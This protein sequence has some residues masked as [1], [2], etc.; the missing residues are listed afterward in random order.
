MESANH[1]RRSLNFSGSALLLASAQRRWAATD[2]VR[3]LKP[4]LARG[5]SMKSPL[6]DMPAS[7][8]SMP[9][10]KTP[11]TRITTLRNGV[12]VATEETYG[13][14]TAMGVFIDA[15]SR[16]E[17]FETNGTTHV[18]QRMGFKVHISLAR[19]Q[20]FC[21]SSVLM[22]FTRRQATSNRTSAQ[23]V[24]NLEALGVNAISSSSREAMVYTAEV[25]RGV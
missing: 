7:L 14:A 17:T 8:S 5:P 4:T 16:N 10:L 11:S 15:G 18:L 12:R 19:V 20:S 2:A 3:P 24:Q 9:Q 23:I 25:V 13:Q 22:C 1:L 21:C 6:L